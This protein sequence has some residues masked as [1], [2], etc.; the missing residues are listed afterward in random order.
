MATAACGSAG[1]KP[2]AR[3]AERVVDGAAVEGAVV[4]TTD[5]AVDGT[6]VGFEDGATVGFIVGTR[7]GI[8]TGVELGAWLGLGDGDGG[9][10][11]A[12]TLRI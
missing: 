4:G 10:V 9:N 12:F 6:A 3:R 5:G 1:T 11:V 8:P 7:D 2:R